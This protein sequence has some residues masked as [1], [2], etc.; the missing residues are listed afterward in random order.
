MHLASLCNQPDCRLAVYS[1]L[2][3]YINGPAFA[4]CMP[5]FRK[6]TVS[7]SI[8][9]TIPL[10]D[11]LQMHIFNLSPAL[12]QVM[13]ARSTR[14][15]EIDHDLALPGDITVLSDDSPIRFA[16]WFFVTYS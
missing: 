10:V 3:T 16:R 12:G 8:H 7:P 2:R 15:D 6:S 13:M 4:L 9:C 14:G 5:R 11:N 1:P